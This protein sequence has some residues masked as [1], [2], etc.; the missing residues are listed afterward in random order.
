MKMRTCFAIAAMFIAVNC[1]AGLFDAVKNVAG[2]VV[3]M[4]NSC[5]ATMPSGANC[6]NAPVDGSSYCLQHKCRMCN[7]LAW[8][9]GLCRNCVPKA[10][11]EAKAKRRAAAESDRRRRMKADERARLGQGGSGRT[12]GR[13]VATTERRRVQTGRRRAANSENEFQGEERLFAGFELGRVAPF[14]KEKG[15]RI[16]LKNAYLSIFEEAYLSYG[17]NSHLLNRIGFGSIPIHADNESDLQP[18]VDKVLSGLK[19]Y[20]YDMQLDGRHVQKPWRFKGK[21]CEITFICNDVKRNSDGVADTYKQLVLTVE[22]PKARLLEKEYANKNSSGDGVVHEIVPFGGYGSERFLHCRSGAIYSVKTNN[23]AWC[24]GIEENIV[25]KNGGVLK[26]PRTVVHGDGLT[27]QGEYRLSPYSVHALTPSSGK[28]TNV[29][30]LTEFA[31]GDL[32]NATEIAKTSS[33]RLRLVLP[34]D[35]INARW[36]AEFIGKNMGEHTFCPFRCLG[37]NEATGRQQAMRVLASAA[38]EFQFPA[39]SFCPEHPL[40]YKEL[41]SGASKDWCRIW[42]ALNA[43]SYDEKESEIVAE[44]GGHKLRLSFSGLPCVL[45]S[46]KCKFGGNGV[47]KEA[48]IA[49]YRRQFGDEAKVDINDDGVKM[50]KAVSSFPR[51]RKQQRE[52]DS[53]S[54][55]NSGLARAVANW[56]NESDP[57]GE[58]TLDSPALIYYQR[59]ELITISSKTIKV[60]AKCDYFKSCAFLSNRSYNR[61]ADSGRLGLV[62]SYDKVPADAVIDENGNRNVI[63]DSCGDELRGRMSQIKENVSSL[64]DK[65]GNVLEITIVGLPLQIALD[66]ERQTRTL[67]AKAE[68]ETQ[69]KKKEAATLNF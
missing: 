11:A 35:A 26:L 8:A 12:S 55:S 62:E 1:P 2:G 22:N 5:L 24:N 41:A 16:K 6:K 54:M 31:A 48:L 42:L 64:K 10:E 46:V 66:A 32:T 47:N 18:Y 33:A 63:N 3:G 4:G 68:E 50:N 40:L 7:D 52:L 14:G 20:G 9:D 59:G 37:A 67:K 49:K 57:F 36:F 21:D 56:A 45:V 28:E 23:I 38:K 58:V 51:T 44:V 65:N 53:M 61:L 43:K 39:D 29:V 25:K 30:D 13:T 19:S 60:L 15:E 34:D 69:R 17:A 27:S